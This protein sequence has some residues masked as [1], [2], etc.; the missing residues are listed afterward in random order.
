MDQFDSY[1][2]FYPANSIIKKYKALKTPSNIPEKEPTAKLAKV[3]TST[4]NL[5]IKA[6]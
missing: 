1:I 4:D 2:I 6:K 3:A 5:K